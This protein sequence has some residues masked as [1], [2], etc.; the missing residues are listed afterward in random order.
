MRNIKKETTRF[1]PTTLRVSRPAPPVV[2]RKAIRIENNI[3]LHTRPKQQNSQQ[4]VKS[5]DETCNEFL[6]EIQDLL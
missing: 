2:N 3:F 1:V 4:F 6:R 5:A